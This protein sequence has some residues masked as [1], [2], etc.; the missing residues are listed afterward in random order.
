[1]IVILRSTLA[2]VSFWEQNRIG[3]LAVGPT[4]H[5]HRISFECSETF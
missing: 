5:Q 1:V 2:I 4:S 3:A